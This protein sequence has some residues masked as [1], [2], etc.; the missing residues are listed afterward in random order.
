MSVSGDGIGENRGSRDSESGSRLSASSCG[1]DPQKNLISFLTNV[2]EVC[3]GRPAAK[4]FYCVV[5]DSL[6]GS[7]GGG[8]AAE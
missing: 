8:S 6:T 4:N 3:R 1:N 5:R 7:R 2:R